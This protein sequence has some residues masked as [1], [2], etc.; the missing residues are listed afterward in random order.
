MPYCNA[1]GKHMLDD[2]RFCNSCGKEVAKLTISAPVEQV[3]AP[4]IKT[5]LRSSIE[6]ILQGAFP[7]LART[8]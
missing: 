5:S 4:I 1:C 2:D 7:G 6:S 3:S 8:I